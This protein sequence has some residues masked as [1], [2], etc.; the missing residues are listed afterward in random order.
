MK[1]SINFKVGDVVSVKPDVEDPDLGINIEG[2]QGRISEIRR[3]T[4]II[5]V[6]WDSVT[7]K[8]MAN[9][10]IDKCEE[11]VFRLE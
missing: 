7:L 8:N 4:N 6:D 2:W 10:V 5:A 1:E 3:E 9:S 11:E